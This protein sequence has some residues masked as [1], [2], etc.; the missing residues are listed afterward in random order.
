MR[1]KE[2]LD[3]LLRGLHKVPQRTCNLRLEP[4]SRPLEAAS[5]QAALERAQSA[6]AG[7]GRAFMRASGTEPLLRVTVEADDETLMQDLLDV[8]SESVTRS[9]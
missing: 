1:R 6:L 3:D 2:D 9:A 5:V 7:R 4:G 8:L